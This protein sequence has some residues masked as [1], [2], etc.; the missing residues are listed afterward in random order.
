M[1]LWC[2][3]RYADA[4]ETTNTIQRITQERDKKKRM[5]NDFQ[6]RDGKAEKQKRLRKKSRCILN[7]SEQFDSSAIKVMLKENNTQ[8]TDGSDRRVKFEHEDLQTA[9]E[10]A[11]IYEKSSYFQSSSCY[12]GQNDATASRVFCGPL[13]RSL[14]PADFVKG[15]RVLCAVSNHDTRQCSC[16]FRIKIAERLSCIPKGSSM[17]L[18]D[19]FIHA[20]GETR[21]QNSADQ[22]LRRCAY[23][24]MVC[25]RTGTKEKSASTAWRVFDASVKNPDSI[26]SILDV[27]HP[28]TK[29]NKGPAI[30]VNELR[31]IRSIASDEAGERLINL[32]AM[33]SMTQGEKRTAFGSRFGDLE[34]DLN[35]KT[36]DALHVFACYDEQAKAHV[37]HDIAIVYPHAISESDI[38]RELN[39]MDEVEKSKAHDIG[40]VCLSD[41]DT[42]SSE[43][44]TSSG[45]DG[46]WGESDEG[47]SASEDELDDDG[48]ELSTFE[49]GRRCDSLLCDQE[50]ANF[51]AE[52]DTTANGITSDSMNSAL[53]E[54]EKAEVARFDPDDVTTFD[55]AEEA[56]SSS[57]EDNALRGR[58]LF[59]QR[60]AYWRRWS[61]RNAR[62]H[63]QKSGTLKRIAH[64]NR[65][66]VERQYPDIKSKVKL[67]IEL[68][69]VLY[70][71]SRKPLR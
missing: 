7:Q 8:N 11:T 36:R 16:G 34:T 6:K 18:T 66:T 37:L 43:A 61:K 71:R 23:A 35:E 21:Y 12:L 33:K 1:S 59:T 32:V 38:E 13:V 52:E 60:I 26:C 39:R 25:F 24:P 56:A 5:L 22:M 28:L 31:A 64:K 54:V 2:I 27:A 17:A 41:D 30:S 29:Y 10:I 14:G 19:L 42:G 15:M 67:L 70:S 40:Y 45:D 69:T 62:M 46:Y 50:L 53:E 3:F 20:G 57:T 44:E 55:L 58:G 47:V 48:I 49:I 63:L 51:I 65:K 4:L 68:T 9:L